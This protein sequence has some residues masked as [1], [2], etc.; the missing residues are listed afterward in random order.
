MVTRFEGRIAAV[1]GGGSG[2]GRAI[3]QRLAEEGAF[4]YVADLSADAA[5]QVTQEI[6]DAGGKGSAEQL[7]ATDIEALKAFYARVDDQH[8]KL[9]VL[10]HQVGMPGPA[11]LDVSLADW[12]LNID[13]NVKSAFYGTALAMD[14][15]KRAEGKGSITMTASTSALIGSPY[16]PIYSLTKGALT[17]YTRALALVGAPD[18]IRVNIICPGPVDTPMLPQFFGREPGADIS[19][20]MNTFIS[21]VPL[22]RPAQP[23]EIAGVVAFLASDDAGFVTGVTIPVDGGLVAK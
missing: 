13:V 7:D 8:G 16:S 11:G 21:F 14:L 6:V 5:K 4:V 18:G 12:Q 19:D 15:L 9:H 1:L 17:A 10:H 22:G 3:A 2:M 23:A 20:L